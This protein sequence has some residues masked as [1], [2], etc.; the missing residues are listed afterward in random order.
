MVIDESCFVSSRAVGK[1]LHNFA[2]EIARA[3]SELQLSVSPF[4][5]LAKCCWSH[6]PRK[7]AASF[8]LLEALLNFAHFPN[9]HHGES[10]GIAMTK[11]VDALGA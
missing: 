1:S 6:R 5:D 2:I 8:F 9:G 4:C 10:P 11:R 7:K 3:L